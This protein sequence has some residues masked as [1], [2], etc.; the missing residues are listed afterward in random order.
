MEELQEQVRRLEGEVARL[1]EQAM[2]ADGLLAQMLGILSGHVELEMSFSVSGG[3]L[4][5]EWVD[6]IVERIKRGSEQLGA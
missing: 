3:T 1:K 6:L 2:L 5:R 4:N